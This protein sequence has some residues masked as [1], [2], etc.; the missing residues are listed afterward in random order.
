MT[1]LKELMANH[2]RILGK[3]LLRSLLAREY[4]DLKKDGEESKQLI[5]D[6]YD[7]YN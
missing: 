5:L 7:P 2:T 3:A 1:S 6:E 4:F